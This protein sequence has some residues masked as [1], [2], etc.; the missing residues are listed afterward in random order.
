M[1]RVVEAAEPDIVEEIDIIA[2]LRS[3]IVVLEDNLAPTRIT[4]GLPG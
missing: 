1:P 2:Q 4:A 3:V